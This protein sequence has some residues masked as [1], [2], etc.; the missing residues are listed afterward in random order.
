MCAGGKPGLRAAVLWPRMHQRSI[1]KAG[2]RRDGEARSHR[3]IDLFAV[4]LTHHQLVQQAQR[5]RV[6]G[7]VEVRGDV[8]GGY[9]DHAVADCDLSVGR[10]T[11]HELL[12]ALQGRVEGRA[13]L[14]LC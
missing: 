1:Q 14:R 10:A 9:A 6:G 4:L 3:L 11:C 7:R 13:P 5:S 12:A 8:G 2:E